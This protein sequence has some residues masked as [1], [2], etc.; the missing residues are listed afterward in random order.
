MYYKQIMC[1]LLVVMFTPMLGM[2][3]SSVLT[4]DDIG[5]VTI[6][7][8]IPQSYGG[9]NWDSDEIGYCNT[10]FG[11]F[12]GTGYENGAVSG[13]YAA[14]SRDIKVSITGNS[15]F[16]FIDA[17]FTAAWSDSLN[18][19][20]MGLSEGMVLFE[21][22]MIANTNVPV[23]FTANYNGIDEV[24]IDS[25]VEV[26][27]HLDDSKVFFLVDDFRTA[28]FVPAPL[29]PAII[30]FGTGIISLVIGRKYVG[31]MA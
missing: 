18:I 26:N 28:D 14:Y 11:G 29:P 21:E 16:S 10:T 19:K 1:T 13:T 7:G 25:G 15:F 24:L 3:S 22:T 4:F 30:L 5:Y 12:A 8:D 17:Y 23:Q 20:I 31:S 2:G 27:P 6:Y 9:F